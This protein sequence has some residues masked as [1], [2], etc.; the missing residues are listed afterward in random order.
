M[1]KRQTQ[2]IENYIKKNKLITLGG[3]A[4]G[5]ERRLE[6]GF[7][8]R[9]LQITESEGATGIASV[10]AIFA[11]LWFCVEG[12]ED[13]GVEVAYPFTNHF[14]DKKAQSGPWLHSVQLEGAQMLH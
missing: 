1:V 5:K 6:R 10:C 4:V 9:P 14:R 7:E 2:K 8:V 12:D 13:D 3:V 11:L